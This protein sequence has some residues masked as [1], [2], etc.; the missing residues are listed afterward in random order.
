MIFF[1]ESASSP[2]KSKRAS[3]RFLNES[4][5]GGAEV[6]VHPADSTDTSG[7]ANTLA[8]AFFHDPVWGWAFADSTRRK[9]QH[10]AWFRLLIGS[11][12]AH[13]WVWT[14]PAY[15]AASVWL[16]PGCP[17]LTEA[18]EARLRPL[19][20]ETVGERSELILEV[21][22]CFD[23]AHPHD[24]EHYYLSLLGTHSDHR[25]AG[26]GMQLLADNLVH[27]DAAGM[28]C[29]LESTNPA[30]LKRYESVGFEPYATFDLPDNGP[31]VTT[32]WRE[33][34]G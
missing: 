27:V 31:A 14:T 5:C 26:I 7:V 12:L 9:V 32:M 1:T 17:E 19:L 16:P 15:E 34:L 21:M 28:P 13:H 11:A 22:R 8:E 3:P 33:P 18:D 20:E 4:S 29:Y 25:G 23:A 10:E 30:N 2:R 24:Q 6:K